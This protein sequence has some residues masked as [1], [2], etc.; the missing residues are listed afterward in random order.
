MSIDDT[1]KILKEQTNK[2]LLLLSKQYTIPRIDLYFLYLKTF[3]KYQ[4][5]ETYKQGKW[6]SF[7]EDMMVANH[8]LKVVKR[9]VRRYKG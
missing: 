6:L 8:T 7:E 9:Y 2:E 3:S 5:R 4:S 1:L